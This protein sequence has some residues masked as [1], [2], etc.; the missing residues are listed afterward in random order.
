M[1]IYNLHVYIQFLP[2]RFETLMEIKHNKQAR[3]IAEERNIANKK[4]YSR[5]E[6][7][8]R[9]KNDTAYIITKDTGGRTSGIARQAIR[10]IADQLRDIAGPTGDIAG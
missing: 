7:G 8:Y 1:Y 2:I 10:D 4:R 5:R 9:R 3:E 6:K